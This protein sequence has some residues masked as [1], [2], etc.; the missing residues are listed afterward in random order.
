MAHVGRVVARRLYRRFRALRPQ[1]ILGD[2]ERLAAGLRPDLRNAASPSSI[3]RLLILERSPF[4]FRAEDYKKWALRMSAQRPELEREGA[5]V[6]RHQFRF[7]GKDFDLRSARDVSEYAPLDWNID[8][9]SGYRWEADRVAAPGGPGA[10]G[11]DIRVAWELNRFH[12][13]PLLG[14]AYWL[15]LDGKTP[16]LDAE[17]FAREFQNECL[18]WLAK[19][20]VR[21]GVNWACAME[22][23][24]RAVNW[25][26]GFHF[27]RL[28]PSLPAEFWSRFLTAMLDH[29]TYIWEN[30]END[31]LFLTNHY[32]ADLV[33]LF[34]I[35]ISFP[36]LADSRKWRE[37]A[38]AELIRESAVQVDRDGVQY[39]GS[40]N[41]HRFSTEL[42]CSL[43]ALCRV[44]NV[45]VPPIFE[46]RVEK[47][48]D[49]VRSYTKPD[50]NAPMIGD[51]DESRLHYFS[52][53]GSW[54]PT[55]HR[56]LL[57]IGGHL[58]G[59]RD[60]MEAAGL[61]KEEALWLLG[62]D[63]L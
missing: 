17:C 2:W 5:S 29:G 41:Y 22:V 8:F 58:F 42:F 32:L 61:R 3:G 26:I 19:N 39:E 52:E 9:F 46:R 54:S 20:P 14:Q 33:G 11:A 62:G 50:G 57:G 4:F 15:A 30:L 55:D 25:I 1:P 35:G 44:S 16:G 53:Y 51:F 48:I 37:F 56:Y 18:D 47:M 45:P 36:E 49:F 60:F 38:F 23:A 13:F 6:L 34:Y 7:F 40:L 43:L 28:S 63:L 59:R 27:F 24:I 10:R 12:H 21:C 31:H